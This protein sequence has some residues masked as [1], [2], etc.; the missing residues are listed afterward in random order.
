M[1]FFNT[2][3]NSPQWVK[4]KIIRAKNIIKNV[5]AYENAGYYQSAM[6]EIKKLLPEVY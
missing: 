6:N 3:H 1:L 4:D 2:T 5:Q